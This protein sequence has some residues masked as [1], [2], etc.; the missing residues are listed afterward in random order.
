[1]HWN[2]SSA[3][4]LSLDD[5]IPN[6]RNQIQCSHPEPSRASRSTPFDISFSNSSVLSSLMAAQSSNHPVHP[7][8]SPTEAKQTP[9]GFN[10]Q[11][12]WRRCPHCPHCLLGLLGCSPFVAASLR[13]CTNP[14]AS[15][16]I[17]G[18]SPP[19]KWITGRLASACPACWI[20]D[21]RH[22][23]RTESWAR[24]K[25]EQQRNPTPSVW[26]SRL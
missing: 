23:V 12:P 4:L 26:F 24:H 15:A 10:G 6:P 1:M 7:N 2:D 17:T 19:A 20:M 18:S 21:I 11:I 13:R 3:A 9:N 25:P 16:R 22:G 14:G 5:A 8:L